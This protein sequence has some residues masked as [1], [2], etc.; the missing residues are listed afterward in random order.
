MM[1]CIIYPAILCVL[2][3]LF[4]TAVQILP[5]Y[6][7]DK[8]KPLYKKTLLILS[9]IIPIYLLFRSDIHGMIDNH[10]YRQIYK[11]ERIEATE[12]LRENNNNNEE[13]RKIKEENE[14]LKIEKEERLKIEADRIEATGYNSEEARKIRKEDEILK[15]KEY[16]RLMIEEERAKYGY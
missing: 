16:N 10:K 3:A 6:T 13:I 15:E 1:E 7:L 9:V 2:G 11:N 12:N 4:F 5:S 8:D 14:R